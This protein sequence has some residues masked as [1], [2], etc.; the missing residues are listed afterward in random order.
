MAHIAFDAEVPKLRR[1][2]LDVECSMFLRILIAAASLIFC[3]TSSFA[4]G[5]FRW[6]GKINGQPV[7]LLLDTGSGVPILVTQPA[8]KRLGLKTKPIKDQEIVSAENIVELGATKAVLELPGRDGRKGYSGK[9]FVDIVEKSAALTVIGVDGVAGWP[10]IR[11]RITQFDAVKGEFHFL[12]EVPAE[13]KGWAKFTIR[14]VDWGTLELVSTKR[15]GRARIFV[16]TGDLVFGEDAIGVPQPLWQG[17][18]RTYP[19]APAWL[20]GN[21]SSDGALNATEYRWL[22]HFS[23]GPLQLTNVVVG[24]IN[25]RFATNDILIGFDTLKGFGLIVDG[26]RHVA[27]L[28]PTA[29][30]EAGPRSERVVLFQPSNLRSKNLIANVVDG[31]S[32]YLAGIRNG[33]LLLGVDRQDLAQWLANPGA[34]WAET[35]H[36][37]P[38]GFLRL[39]KASSDIP[40]TAQTDLKLR[41]G[42]QT[43]LATI[44]QKSLTIAVTAG[45]TNTPA[46]R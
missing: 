6:D 44:L 29:A 25:P 30:S 21:W 41:R 39:L 33:D 27:Y 2:M 23:I 14:D 1:S 7:H 11:R 4:Q 26:R 31:S 28:R 15:D 5:G 36:S 22:S 43:I 18:K 24:T 10:L 13:A 34:N 40:P 3:L 38:M 19:N 8:A 46:S 9:A 12:D 42:T 45:R 35:N 20:T 37:T 32:A 16:D 17:L